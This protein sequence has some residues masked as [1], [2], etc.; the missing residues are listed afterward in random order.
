MIH[1]EM[2]QAEAYFA[3]AAAVVAAY[4]DITNALMWWKCLHSLIIW[5]AKLKLRGLSP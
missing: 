2:E 1:S 5:S 3:A 4:E